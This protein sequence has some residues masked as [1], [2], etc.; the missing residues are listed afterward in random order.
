MRATPLTQR[1]AEKLSVQPVG[2]RAVL[3][4]TERQLTN[5]DTVSDAEHAVQQH[6]ETTRRAAC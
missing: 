6:K 5:M 4:A 1:M 3:H 2:G